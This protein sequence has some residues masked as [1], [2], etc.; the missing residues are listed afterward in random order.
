MKSLL[1]NLMLL[2]VCFAVT[3]AKAQ[4]LDFMGIPLDGTIANFQSK[5]LNKGCRIMK[6]NSRIPVG[7]RGYDGIFAGKQAAIFVYYNPK[8]QIVY[9]AR[10]V[11]DCGE[12]KE[13]ANNVFYRYKRML[14][15]KYEGVSLNSDMLDEQKEFECSLMVLQPPIQ[16]GSQVLGAI[17]VYIID[18]DTYPVEY[19]VIINYSDFDN[20]SKNEKSE[21]DDL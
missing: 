4:H 1:K 19:S 14:F 10:S 11:I 9:Q 3:S 15:E 16:E 8:T 2:I 6:Y 21:L 17:E 7:I 5:L 20:S 13:N 18:T 12:S